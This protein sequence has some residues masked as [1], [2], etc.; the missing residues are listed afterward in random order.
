MVNDKLMYQI[1]IGEKLVH[2]IENTT[3]LD[4]Y[5]V[6]V[7]GSNPWAVEPSAKVRNFK[8]STCKN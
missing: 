2:E 4:L 1:F 7:Y 5:D 8:F 6:T 3:P